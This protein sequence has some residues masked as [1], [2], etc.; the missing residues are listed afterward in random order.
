MRGLATFVACMAL[1]ACALPSFDYDA[2]VMFSSTAGPVQ[3]NHRTI[4]PGAVWS[5]SYSSFAD[6]VRDPS[7]VEIAGRT[8]PIGPAAC[9]ALCRDCD[10]D[11]ASLQFHIEADQVSVT[12]TCSDGDRDFILK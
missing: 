10:F 5:A 9:A 7:I 8:V 12:G 4:A 3:L 2:T 1:G 11:R 6:A